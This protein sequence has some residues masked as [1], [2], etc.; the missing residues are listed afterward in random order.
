MISVF[1][2]FEEKNIK[3]FKFI[4]TCIIFIWRIDTTLYF[5]WF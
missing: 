4:E 1:I 3:A 5:D 2:S